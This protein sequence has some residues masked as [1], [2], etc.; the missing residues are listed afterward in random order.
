MLVAT[1]RGLVVGYVSEKHAVSS[2]ALKT[3]VVYLSET[4]LCTHKST[5]RYGPEDQH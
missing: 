3:E 5:R 4:F 1:L 2:S